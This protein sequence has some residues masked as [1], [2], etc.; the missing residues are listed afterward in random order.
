MIIAVY[1][2]DILIFKDND[3]NMKKIQDLLT[4]WFKITELDK[5][6]HYLNMEI[7]IDD[8]KTSIYQ[9]NYLMNVLNYFKFYNCKSCKISMNSDTVNYVELFIKQTDKETIVYY[10]LTINSLIWAMI[11]T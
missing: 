3:K 11:M 5:M 1:V 2:D 6:S 8:D 4:R 7:D 9:T 10:Q